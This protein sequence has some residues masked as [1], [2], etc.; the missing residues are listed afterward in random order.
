LFHGTVKRFI[1]PIKIEGLKKMKRQYV[2]L[3]QDKETAL[4]VGSRRGKA[5]IL[6]VKALEMQNKGFQFYKSENDV[7]LTDI[8][9]SDFIDFN[10]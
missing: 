9:P 4:K 6:V 8:V 3:S 10:N 5:I 7:W 1:Q 2:H